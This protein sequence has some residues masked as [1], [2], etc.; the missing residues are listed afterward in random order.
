MQTGS[1][2]RMPSRSNIHVMGEPKPCFGP[3]ENPIGSHRE[4]ELEDVLGFSVVILHMTG[5]VIAN[6]T[7]R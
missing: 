4:G 1:P 5:M 7:S 3:L 6:S 2:T